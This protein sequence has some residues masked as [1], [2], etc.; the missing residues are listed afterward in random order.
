MNLSQFSPKV[1]WASREMVCTPSERSLTGGP[2]QVT[3][4]AFSAPP[5]FHDGKVVGHNLTNESICR[6]IFVVSHLASMIEAFAETY[7]TRSTR[8]SAAN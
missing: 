5:V 6:A 2:L 1:R 4:G 8:I 3:K 7:P